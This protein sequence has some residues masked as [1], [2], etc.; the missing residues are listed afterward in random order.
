M[1]K[2]KKNLEMTSKRLAKDS[3]LYLAR[4]LGNYII[5]IPF[6]LLIIVFIDTP[7]T[8]IK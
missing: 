3:Q 6:Y 7:Y 5:I 8:C 1:A 2:E 4:L